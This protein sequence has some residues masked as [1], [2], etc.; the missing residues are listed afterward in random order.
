MRD[1][2]WDDLRFLLAIARGGSL[3]EAARRL[4]VNESTVARRLARAEDRLAVR[5]FERLG[6]RM[7]ATAAGE[8]LLGHAGRIESE[9][10]AATEA[11]SGGDLRVDGLVRLTAVPLVANRLLAPALPRLLTA[12]PGLRV[13]LIAEPA[14][15]SVLRR[16][17]DLALRLARPSD[18]GA[19]VARRIARLD[20][21]V[22][23]APGLNARTAPWL[24]YETRMEELPQSRW[25]LDRID[26]S[27]ATAMPARV[28]DGETLLQLLRA[29]L[30]KSLLPVAVAAKTDG[31]VQ[32]G[33]VCLSRELWLLVH[34]DLKDLARVR[35][36]V[37]W[38]LGVFGALQGSAGERGGRQEPAV[39]R[40]GPPGG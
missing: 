7:A 20:Y 36:V 38:L 39:P 2:P 11:L 1:L 12:H 28:N 9:V 30:G 22:F 18:E 14:A 25:I 26:G 23:L 24:G 29:G 15:L 27:D 37:D 33:P 40:I 19:A 21:A 6:G 34:P 17:V 8:R 3:A 32:S 31:L 16:D 10:L 35:V 13:D 5:L 4:G